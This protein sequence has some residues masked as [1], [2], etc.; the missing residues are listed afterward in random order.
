[1]TRTGDDR[2]RGQRERHDSRLDAARRWE[3]QAEAIERLRNKVSLLSDA[4]RRELAERLLGIA[5]GGSRREMDRLA[6]HFLDSIHRYVGLRFTCYRVRA[7]GH[8]DDPDF[9]LSPHDD[10]F[11]VE[12]VVVPY[13]A[14]DDNGSSLTG[15]VAQLETAADALLRRDGIVDRSPR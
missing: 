10:D 15:V 12:A 3:R 4:G 2:R 9:I 5:P 13:A 14:D 7:P 6:S 1:M 8:H 11:R